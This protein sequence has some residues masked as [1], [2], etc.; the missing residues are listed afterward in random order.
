MT[1]RVA[2]PVLREANP[3]VWEA[4]G[5]EL[6]EPEGGRRRDPYWEQGCHP[7]IV[8]R[9]WDELG[10]ELPAEAR[11]QAR[12][13]PVLAHGQSDRII[14]FARGTAYALWLAPQDRAAA[15]ATGAGSVWRWGSGATSDLAEI[16]PGWIW[17]RWYA[18]E[19][20]WIRHAYVT[21]QVRSA[22]PVRKPGCAPGPP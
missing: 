22:R 13:R 9:L 10:H 3:T 14:A 7:D 18:G 2:R 15:A 5:E 12:G 4:L 1:P 20:E 16:G 19:P 11:A 17:G 21:A 6:P 8:S